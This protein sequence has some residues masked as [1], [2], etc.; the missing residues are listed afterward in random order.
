MLRMRWPIL[1]SILLLGGCSA[2]EEK[3][4]TL[5]WSQQK[6]YTEATDEMNGGTR[7][8]TPFSRIA[9]L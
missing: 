4:E 7:M 2:F 3:D 5:T 8:R 6:L 1:L 9:G